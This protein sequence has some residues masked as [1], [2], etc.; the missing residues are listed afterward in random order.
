MFLNIEMTTTKDR[1]LFDTYVPT[2]ESA[3]D[4]LKAYYFK[5]SFNVFA[6]KAEIE[7]GEEVAWIDDEDKV[8]VAKI[9]A[10]FID[11]E[12]CLNDDVDAFF[13]ADGENG[14]FG[15]AIYAMQHARAYKE[16]SV[17]KEW[18]PLFTVYMDAFYVYPEYRNKGIGTY[19]LNNI[20]EIFRI[21]TNK[22][23]HAVGVIL[24][25]QCLKGESMT[26]KEEAAMLRKMQR[27]FKRAGYKKISDECLMNNY[28]ARD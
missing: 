5:A 20:G 24:N 11:E 2:Q 21:F 4:S 10:S 6:S 25:P 3:K 23:I 12:N 8:Q 9:V 1:M 16:L 27:L 19:L 13:M 15:N 22:D 18:K 26:E 17:N 28:G 14:D 7:N